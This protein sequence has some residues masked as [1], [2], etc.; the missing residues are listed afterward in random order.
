MLHAVN[1]FLKNLKSKPEKRFN[2]VFE[3]N[4][5]HTQEAVGSLIN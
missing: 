4:L 5:L 2:F 1:T 3:F